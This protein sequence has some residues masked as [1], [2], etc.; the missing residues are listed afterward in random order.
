MLTEWENMWKRGSRNLEWKS[1]IGLAF[2]VI[3]FKKD[4]AKLSKGFGFNKCKK[5]ENKFKVNF[6]IL[7]QLNKC[8]HIQIVNEFYKS[9]DSKYI[10]IRENNK[11]SNVPFLE[12]HGIGTSQEQPNIQT[13]V[14]NKADGTE[15]GLK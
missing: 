4:D 12:Q 7:D 15:D 2:K 6:L 10:D 11:S 3:V 9:I 8:N 14:W 1:T 13:R 5:C